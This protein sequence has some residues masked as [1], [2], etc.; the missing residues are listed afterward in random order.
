[1]VSSTTPTPSSPNATSA[2]DC[3]SQILNDVVDFIE[4]H[5]LQSVK[6]RSSIVVELNPGDK[7]S[8]TGSLNGNGDKKK[9]KVLQRPADSL[10]SGLQANTTLNDNL[11]TV[12]VTNVGSMPI[13]IDNHIVFA[14]LYCTNDDEFDALVGPSLK[15]NVYIDDIECTCLIDSGSQVSTMSNTT[16]KSSF[17]HLPLH[18]ISSLQIKGA[19]G[20]EV[21]YLGYIVVTLDLK[22]EVFW[23]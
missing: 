13:S 18:D 3:D 2:L 16:Y 17:A 22:S 4:N 14:E 5:K 15:E 21:P 20:S 23:M 7:M 19:G 6:L 8:F 9:L 1:M 12:M 11:V 10:P